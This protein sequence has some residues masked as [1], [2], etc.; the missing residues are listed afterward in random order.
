MDQACEYPE[1]DYLLYRVLRVLRT[2]FPS[3]TQGEHLQDGIN[4]LGMDSY[5]ILSYV[6]NKQLSR[7]LLDSQR[8]AV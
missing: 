4:T 8:I 2:G 7:F 6:H 3:F 1:V 5:F